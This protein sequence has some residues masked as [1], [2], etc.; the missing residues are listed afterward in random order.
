MV[1]VI[2]IISTFFIVVGFLISAILKQKLSKK[3][4][5]QSLKFVILGLLIIYIF[6]SFLTYKN[7]RPNELI[8]QDN[9]IEFTENYG[10]KIK[11]E[12]IQNIQQTTLLPEIESR[13][14][15]FSLIQ[16][17]KGVFKT[18]SGEQIYL[19]I[20]GSDNPILKI[21][22]KN[23]E[24]IYFNSTEK[25]IEFEYRKLQNIFSYQRKQ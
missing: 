20:N 16:I 14:N 12:D 13:I 1:L 18:K 23:Q 24:K 21:T 3:K 6:T 4:Y 9:Y 11:F 15:G 10:V 7:S 25:N 5:N 19:L 22:K 2:I 17:R 8:I